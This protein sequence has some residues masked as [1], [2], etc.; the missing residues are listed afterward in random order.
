MF[1]NLSNISIPPA[2]VPFQPT[3]NF[4]RRFGLVICAFQN[5]ATYKWDNDNPIEI[6]VIR[7]ILIF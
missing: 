4:N 2:V 5:R 6:V 7:E 1:Y 3:F